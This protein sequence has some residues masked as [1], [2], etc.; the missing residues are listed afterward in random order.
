VRYT[1]QSG[2]A[3]VNES[4]SATAGDSFDAAQSRADSFLAEDVEIADF[5]GKADMSTA[6]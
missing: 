5:T 2:K 4:L 6:T 1:L 3:T